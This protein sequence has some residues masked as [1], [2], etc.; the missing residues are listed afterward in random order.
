[1]RERLRERKREAERGFGCMSLFGEWSV[2]VF[3]WRCIWGFVNLWS[4]K[5][6][7]ES[8]EYEE[9]D[10]PCQS[11]QSFSSS[12]LQPFCSVSVST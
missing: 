7:T 11:L 12:D 5:G 8:G 3:V 6:N 1:M 2:G 10:L 4:S 9:L